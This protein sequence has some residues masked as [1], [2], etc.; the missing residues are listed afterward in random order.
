MVK[1]LSVCC[2]IGLKLAFLART[3]IQG[4]PC[5]VRVSWSHVVRSGAAFASRLPSGTSSSSRQAEDCAEWRPRPEPEIVHRWAQAVTRDNRTIAEGLKSSKCSS[6]LIV[7]SW[8]SLRSLCSEVLRDSCPPW[9]KQGDCGS[10]ISKVLEQLP[11]LPGAG[12]GEPLLHLLTGAIVNGLHFKNRS[13][14]T[15]GAD[16]RRQPFKSFTVPVRV[17]Q[18]IAGVTKR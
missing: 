18:K 11:I 3:S 10:R 2:Q 15:L 7:S 1:R 9:V 13:L 8:L 6:M 16:C 5:S 12:I 17:R 4:H 14:A